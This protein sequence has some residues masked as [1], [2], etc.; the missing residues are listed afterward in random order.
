MYRSPSLREIDISPR[1]LALMVRSVDMTSPES[2]ALK[3]LCKRAFT[4]FAAWE[5]RV[6]AFRLQAATWLAA[7]WVAGTEHLGGLGLR[8]DDWSHA[9]L[10]RGRRTTQASQPGACRS[11]RRE[12][13]DR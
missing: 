5:P 10:R 11:R 9:L 7:A 3:V 13:G 12:G 8:R 6:A 1:G 2:L 4:S